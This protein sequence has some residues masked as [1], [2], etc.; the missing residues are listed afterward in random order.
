MSYEYMTKNQILKAS[1]LAM[2]LNIEGVFWKA[3][4]LE[5]ANVLQIGRNCYF[6]SD[7]AIKI[8]SR[9][10]EYALAHPKHMKSQKA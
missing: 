2:F 4:A 6:L 8:I 9:L 3:V 5:R 7:E 10:N 1:N